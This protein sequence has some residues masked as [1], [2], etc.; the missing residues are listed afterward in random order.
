V[1][2]PDIPSHRED[3]CSLQMGLFEVSPRQIEE[4]ARNAGIDKILA[5][6]PAMKEELAE[7]R[8]AAGLKALEAA[9]IA[10]ERRGPGRP[11]NEG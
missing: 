10:L 3:W 2:D 9:G 6:L 8:K 5:E 7:L 1:D 4:D 11:R